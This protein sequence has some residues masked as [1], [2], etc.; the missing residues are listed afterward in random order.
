[1]HNA[2][3]SCLHFFP[4]SDSV[5]Y[6]QKGKTIVFIKQIIKYN[7]TYKQNYFRSQLPCSEADYLT[8]RGW[9]TV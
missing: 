1:M 2:H 4:H 7:Y 5:D 8:S 6:P 9:L 3:I